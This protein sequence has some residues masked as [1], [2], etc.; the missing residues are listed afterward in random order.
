MVE[1]ARRRHGAVGRR[2]RPSPGGRCVKERG[3]TGRDSGAGV[4]VGPVHGVEPASKKEGCAGAPPAHI[5]RR[6]IL[7]GSCRSGALRAAGWSGRRRCRWVRGGRSRWRVAGC[8]AA[9]RCRRWLGAYVG[10]RR[11]AQRTPRHAAERE[12]TRR[13]CRT[14]RD[15]EH[16]GTHR[17]GEP[18]RG[19]PSLYARPGLRSV[20][21]RRSALSR[22][23]ALRAR[24]VR[25]GR[26]CAAAGRDRG[27][28]ESEGWR[29]FKGRVTFRSWKPDG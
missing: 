8:E 5:A 10:G 16:R 11:P 29:T 7:P 3:G 14:S 21:G 22:R 13:S 2:R 25:R 28:P 17:A 26:G 1:P 4:E 23:L 18:R 15:A 19:E 6:V 12:G 27:R 20:V 9:V 24:G